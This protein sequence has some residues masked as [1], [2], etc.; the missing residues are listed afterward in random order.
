MNELDQLSGSELASQARK[1]RRRSVD[2]HIFSELRR[3]IEAGTLPPGTKL[4][5]ER[6]L[7]V[8]H[9]VGRKLVRSALDRLRKD[10]LIERRVG[11]GT[12]VSSLAGLRTIATS[13]EPPAISPLDAIEARRVIEVGAIEL[14]VARATDED[15][16][17]IKS[18]LE[19]VAATDDASAFRALMFA[20]NLD[21]I[22]ATRNPLLVAMYEM[23]IAARAKAGWDRLAYLV[24]R[25]EQRAQSVAVC[26]ELLDLLHRGDARRA[27]NLRYRSLSAMIHTIMTFS[28]ET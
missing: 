17:R 12:F 14:V 18:R 27:A 26:Q 1:S 13:T 10:G 28:D 5:T 15:F 8:R 25:P 21:I 16:A 7:A 11:S 23:L 6:T 22:R 19:A 20:L 3:G 4:P 24:E 2:L 9:G